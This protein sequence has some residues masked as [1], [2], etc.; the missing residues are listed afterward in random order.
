MRLREKQVKKVYE[1]QRLGLES[2]FY[3]CLRT[4]D[5]PDI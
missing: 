2:G 3:T 4:D 1:I 5:I